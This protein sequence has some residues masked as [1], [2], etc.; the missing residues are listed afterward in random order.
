[1]YENWYAYYVE[2]QFCMELGICTV[3]KNNFIIKLDIHTLLKNI[4]FLSNLICVHCC[5]TVLCIKLDMCTL[6]NSFYIKFDMYNLVAYSL[7]IKLDIFSLW[8]TD[9][10]KKLIRV[11]CLETIFYIKCHRWTLLRNSFCLSNVIWI[12]SV[13]EYFL[14]RFICILFEETVVLWKMIFTVCWRTVFV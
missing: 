1:M 8:W 11:L 12:C 3:L 13:E 5:W 6:R 10:V 9:C 14:W 2:Q 7:Y 4:F